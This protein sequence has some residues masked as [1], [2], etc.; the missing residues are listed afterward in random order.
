MG[1]PLKK[2]LASLPPGLRP[3]I[4]IIVA[5]PLPPPP[6]HRSSVA[7]SPPLQ[8]RPS[9]P[10]SVPPQSAAP[11]SPPSPPLQCRPQSPPPQCTT[12]V[13]RSSIAPPPPLVYRSRTPRVRVNDD[14]E[15][16]RA[17]DH[18]TAAPSVPPAKAHG[19]HRCQSILTTANNSAGSPRQRTADGR[20]DAPHGQ[21]PLIAPPSPPAATGRCRSLSACVDS[22]RAAC[23]RSSAAT[24]CA[25]EPHGRCR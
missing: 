12:P 17:A 19:C 4:F 25:S 13:Y 22:S 7:P 18:G 11:V 15:P 9:P 10:A 1:Y 21:F 14:I 8:C 20:V 2:I 5:E 3:S 24:G 23:A 6:V 16:S